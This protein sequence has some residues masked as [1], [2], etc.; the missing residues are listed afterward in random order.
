MIF[1]YFYHSL[2][3]RLND[4]ENHRTESEYEDMLIRAHTSS[5]PVA[6]LGTA[7]TP[8]SLYPQ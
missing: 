3:R 2:A 5:S 7:P 1:N 6:F 8:L 4:L